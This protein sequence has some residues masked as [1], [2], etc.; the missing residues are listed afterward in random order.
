MLITTQ[1]PETRPA[2]GTLTQL[3]YEAVE[4]FD[5]PDALQYKAGGVYHP[6]SHRDLLR[7]VR[8]LG[9]GL[10]SLGVRRGDR[11]AILS[12][13][14]P[15]WAIADYACLTTGVTDVP[16]YPSLPAEQ[17]VYPLADAGAVAIFVSTP[18][19][20][21]KVAAI[22]S[23]VPCL[24]TVIT[25]AGARVE[26]AD[27]TLDEVEAMGAAHDNDAVAAGYR[28][29][30][31]TVHPDDLATIIYTS[32]TTGE[33]KGVMLTHDN[34]FSNVAASKMIL[35]GRQDD[36][37]LSFLPLSHIFE[38]M[39]GHYYMF[40]TGASICYAESM[41]TLIDDFGVV[42]PSVVFSVPRIYEKVLAGA[43]DKARAAGGVTARI[44]FWAHAVGE[45][46]VSADIAGRTPSPWLKARY[47]LADR[48]VFSKIRA[49]MG[50]RI[51]FFVSGGAPL[52]VEV[53]RFFQACGLTIYEGYGLTETS[54]VITVNRPTHRRIGTVGVPIA[55]V[56]VGIADD[57]E[58]CCRGPNVMLGY[59]NQPEATRA[60]IDEDG[61]FHTGDI[62]ELTDG[63]LRITDRKKDLIVTA[64]GK[65]IAPQPIENQ[66]RQNRY[67]LQAVM[68]GDRRRFPALL[69]VPNFTQLESWAK[70]KQLTW[71]DHASLLQNPD[72]I[73]KMDRE[74]L[75]NLRGLAP[76]ETPKR[77]ILLEHDFSIERGELTPTLK[78]KRRVIDAR[79]KEQIDQMYAS[80]EIS[81]EYA[82]VPQHHHE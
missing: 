67:V 62:G 11:V 36:R 69:V 75:G 51:H 9:L 79:Y 19:Q 20:A 37:C 66:V 48:L 50:G 33:P 35:P 2:P 5:K 59:Y 26:G 25:F 14:R 4:G 31:L 46:W 70:L 38:R 28:A 3:F 40:A 7:R 47:A 1:R 53:N 16:L 43:A 21:V 39:G 61:W 60:A 65:N 30:A 10:R 15:E 80:T 45:E 49:R 6:I 77:V 27:L 63:Y 81:A 76:F 22:R 12:E 18:A 73:A 72:V 32:G 17:I 56:E 74:V 29:E 71:T 23:R 34:I 82:G 42:R 52:A 8:H 44:F 41:D 58:I 55:G 24:R 13:N 68:I 64:G 78:V 54:P 57:G